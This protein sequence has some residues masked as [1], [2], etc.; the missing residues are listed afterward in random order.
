MANLISK[1]LKMISKERE[2]I[3]GLAAKLIKA[4]DDPRGSTLKVIQV[5]EKWLK[6]RNLDYDVQFSKDKFNNIIISYGG[7]PENGLIFLGHLD[8]VP[9][10]DQSQWKYGPFSATRSDDKLYGRGAADMK[11]AV[12]A[13]LY[14]L[15]ALIENGFKPKNGITIVLT[16]DEEV[17]GTNGTGYLVSNGLLKGKYAIVGEPTGSQKTGF[18]IVVGERGFIWL[19]LIVKGK[20]AHGSLPI[21][22]LNAIEEAVSIIYDLRG[23]LGEIHE[24]NK[25]V[26]EL[27]NSSI[28]LLENHANVLG[29]SREALIES[30]LNPT[31]NIGFIR[32]GNSINV[33]SD[34]CIVGLDIRIPIGLSVDVVLNVLKKYDVNYHIV[35]IAEPSM[36]NPNS[37]IVKIVSE[38]FNKIYNYEPKPLVT[39]ASS[40]AHYL[41]KAGIPTV[42]LGPGSETVHSVNEYVYIDD[43]INMTKVYAILMGS[44][45]NI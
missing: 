29:I 21:A 42:L 20:A 12:S 26:S 43:V 9:V 35:G 34:E 45:D 3:L 38:A 10:S 19:Q 27:L 17:G 31:L 33:V 40:D 25:S 2:N 13:F 23:R 4:G 32:G 41:R 6:E 1:T 8:V 36:T 24:I 39:Y 22:G 5:I 18:S 37:P 7:R 30:I 11:G 14:A 15:Y 16:S 44:V 28:S